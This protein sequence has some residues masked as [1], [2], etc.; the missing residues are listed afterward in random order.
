MIIEA[1]EGLPLPVVE[2]A[3][4]VVAA[5]GTGRGY[6]AGAPSVVKSDDAFYL[7]YRLRRPVGEGRGYCVVVAA[8]PDG[9]EFETV[10][11][12][13]RDA[14][15]AESLE[16]PALVQRPDGGWRIYVSCATPGTDHWWIDA[17]DASDPCDFDPSTRMTV[18][19]GDASTAM[20]D[21]VVMLRDDDW[22]LWVSCH[23]LT[24]VG[25]TDRM[26]SRFASSYDG[27]EWSFSDDVLPDGSGTWYER[28]SRIS[29]VL[30]VDGRWVAYYD[31][32]ATAS[33]NA[34][35]RTG[36]AVGDRPDRLHP[37]RGGP[38]AVSPWGSG[39]LRYVSIL[40][41]D[42]DR[43]RL[44]FE[45]CNPDGSHA[46]YTQVSVPPQPAF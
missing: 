33:E 40:R 37:L 34:E 9:T 31:G 24:E 35:E 32:R 16:R 38:V 5:P 44:Y 46:L 21:P 7:A 42:R 11:V 17:L 2:S 27:L 19:P 45:A 10:K 1:P 12:L 39:S 14:F 30:P 4:Q 6:W 26:L 43:Y 20:K 13:D 29:S 25:E 22:L 15:G 41:V 8:S 28:G 36:V 3:T 18:L 23:A